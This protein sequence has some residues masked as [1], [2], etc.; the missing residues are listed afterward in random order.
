MC[1]FSRAH[2]SYD[3]HTS[4]HDYPAIGVN[5]TGSQ[6]TVHVAGRYAAPDEGRGGTGGEE[7][8]ESLLAKECWCLCTHT[9]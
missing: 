3:L 4:T 5:S 6:K 9:L 1:T 8:L 7:S 2:T